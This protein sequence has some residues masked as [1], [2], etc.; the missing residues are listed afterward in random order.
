MCTLSAIRLPACNGLRVVFNRDELRSRPE[1]LPPV[2]RK[3]GARTAVMPIDPQSDGTWIAANDAGLIFAL[4]NRSLR[5]RAGFGL[6]VVDEPRNMQAEACTPI[7]RGVI[8][9]ALLHC[10]TLSAALELVVDIDA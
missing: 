8:V 6:H 2:V 1:A 7:S 9:P 10:S 4:L 3:F 5:R